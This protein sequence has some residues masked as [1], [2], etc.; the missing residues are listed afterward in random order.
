[1]NQPQ[2]NKNKV[3]N[4]HCW[5]CRGVIIT[6]WLLLCC[7]CCCSRL[8]LL[9]DTGNNNLTCPLSTTP[10]GWQALK[11]QMPWKC[12][13]S[14]TPSYIQS[15][16]SI[17]EKKQIKIRKRKKFPFFCFGGALFAIIDKPVW[18][19]D[20]WKSNEQF[21]P[22]SVKNRRKQIKIKISVQ[23]NKEFISSKFTSSL[24]RNIVQIQ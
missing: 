3:A 5:H 1:M 13:L 24:H 23:T 21:F 8:R 2:E 10:K 20:C 18:R 14:S 17:F 6:L 16:F 19:T 12:E 7:C 22:F 11:L 4:Y 15:Y 9:L